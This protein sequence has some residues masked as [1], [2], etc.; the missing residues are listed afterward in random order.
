MLKIYA[1]KVIINI[2]IVCHTEWWLFSTKLAFFVRLYTI[3]TMLFFNKNIE[4]GSVYSSG[5]NY[6]FKCFSGFRFRVVDVVVQTAALLAFH[7]L[8]HD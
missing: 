4:S 5:L 8:A 3:K 7:C 2:L 6:L 1:K